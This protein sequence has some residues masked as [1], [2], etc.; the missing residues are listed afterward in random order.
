M[1]AADRATALAIKAWLEPAGEAQPDRS[2][3]YADLNWGWDPE[4][5]VALKEK[6]GEVLLKDG[7]P[8]LAHVP[9]HGDAAPLLSAMLSEDRYQVAQED[10]RGHLDFSYRKLRA[11]TPIRHAARPCRSGA[12]RARSL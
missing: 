5:L 1:S 11:R 8:V 2:T 3:V 12:G 10:R 9:P 4:W 7:H 6:P